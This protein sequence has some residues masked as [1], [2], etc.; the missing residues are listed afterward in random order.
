M[1]FLMSCPFT[2]FPGYVSL[3]PSGYQIT[4]ALHECSYFCRSTTARTYTLKPNALVFHICSTIQGISVHLGFTSAAMADSGMA[5]LVA[6]AMASVGQLI[7]KASGSAVDYSMA[8]GIC[9]VDYHH[10][11]ELN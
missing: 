2:R 1:L 7:T 8:A 6:A 11:G 10:L 3:V 4:L 5:S 9:Q